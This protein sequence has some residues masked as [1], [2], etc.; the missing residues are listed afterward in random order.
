MN[1]HHLR[2]ATF[3]IETGNNFILIDPMLGKKGSLPAFSYVKFKAEKNPLVELP[4][5]AAELLGK[6]T[7]CFITHSQT[8]NIRAFQHT[9]HLDR[10][11]EKFL[12]YK[13]IP[14]YTFSHDALY[15]KNLGLNVQ[16]GIEHWKEIQFLGGRLVAVPAKHGHGWISKFMA[17]GCGFFLDLPNEPSIY[18]SG[19]TVLT[20]DVK[21]AIFQFNPDITVVAAGEAQ[22]DVGKPILMTESEV[23]KFIQLS[24]KHVIANHFEA[25]NHCPVKR[26][27][28][29][30][31]VAEI[32]EKDRVYIPDDGQTLSFHLN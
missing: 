13:Q 24:P 20:E 25:L 3:I 30:N 21:T 18:I 9:D 28:I 8:F 11:G 27:D 6:V 7:H 16:A 5:N 23:R 29:Q 31:L 4:D 12:A 32:G 1:I 2:S 26:A 22:M 10:T 19:D 17:N 15:L 14:V